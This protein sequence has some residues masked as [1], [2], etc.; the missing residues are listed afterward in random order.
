MWHRDLLYKLYNIAHN[1]ILFTG[2]IRYYLINRTVTPIFNNEAGTPFIPK[3]GVP[4]G[5]V[6][7]PTL[8]N[9]FV[10]DIP[11]PKYIDTIRLQFADDI[12][13]V[14]R[15]FGRGKNKVKQATTKLKNELKIIEYWE[16]DWRISVNPNKCK[17]ATKIQHLEEFDLI[18]DIQI[19]NTPVQTT[20]T[21][22]ILGYKFNF[23]KTST[24]HI[25]NITQKAKMNIQKLYR[26]KTAPVKIKK[27]LYKALIRPILEY[28][29]IQINNT[30]ITNKH[31]IQ[32]IQNKATRYI[33]N[34]KLSDRIRSETIH[35]TLNLEA[36]N[37]CI[38][39][40]KT[41]QLYK[42]HDRYYNNN[43]YH[44]YGTDYEINED[45][46]LEQPK[47]LAKSVEEIIYMDPNNCPWYEPLD[48]GDWTP[49][50]SIFI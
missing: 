20:N 31:K 33:N 25:A 16:K 38:N 23:A 4:Q 28:P 37:V 9:I 26:F 46:R 7:G 18:N 45:P 2:L 40:M 19:D 44:Y 30:G 11:P 24:T 13:T 12:V 39:K 8:F 41:K 49:A 3:A 22:K 42:I 43:T 1:N 29:V 32:K 27:H 47:P 48:P 14:T 34:T 15:S 50:D 36:M 6:I 35:D 17:I 10:N 5:S 21:V